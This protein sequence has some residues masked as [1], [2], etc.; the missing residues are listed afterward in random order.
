MEEEEEPEFEES[1]K[2]RVKVSHDDGKDEKDEDLSDG[3]K[4]ERERQRDIEEREAFAKRLKEKD[5]GRSKKY[6]RDGEARSP[7]EVKTR[8]QRQA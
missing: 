1:A 6:G 8:V 4:E 7:R 5:D 3:A 2:K